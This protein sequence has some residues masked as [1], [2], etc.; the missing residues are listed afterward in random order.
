MNLDETAATYGLFQVVFA[1]MADHVAVAT[2]RLRELK[3]PGLEFET[4]FR[5]DFSKTFKQFRKELRQF[6]GRSPVADY[7][8]AVR[9]ACEIISKLAAWRNGRIH[10][11]VRMTDTGYALYDWRTRK[12]LEISREQI[13]KNIHLG[14]KAIVTLEAN[15][16]HLV[17]Q[18]NFDAE[19][20]KLFSTLPEIS[21]E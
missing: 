19:F 3:E 15:V 5:Q 9:E 20:E 14:V 1:D 12:R 6:D 17:H 16:Q 2:F 4:V 11:R 18:L 7:L 13:E 8:R 21:G 10:P